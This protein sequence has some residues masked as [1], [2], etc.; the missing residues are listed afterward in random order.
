MT[1]VEHV[2]VYL[3]DNGPTIA[4]D[5]AIMMYMK[6]RGD[7]PTN[8]DQYGTYYSYFAPQ[9]VCATGPRALWQKRRGKIVLTA[10]GSALAATLDEDFV[11]HTNKIRRER[12]VYGI[13]EKLTSCADKDLVKIYDTLK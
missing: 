6:S 2:L 4:R 7:V 12:L 5:L 11:L 1:L 9:S 10:R 8:S 13:I 3:R